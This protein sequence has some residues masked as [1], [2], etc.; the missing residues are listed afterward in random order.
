[1]Y[2]Q[3]TNTTTVDGGQ[4]HTAGFAGGAGGF[5]YPDFLLSGETVSG[6][7]GGKKSKL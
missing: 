5:T 7:A 2:T 1:M 4:W 6:V 3:I